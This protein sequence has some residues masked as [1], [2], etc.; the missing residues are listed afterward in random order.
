MSDASGTGAADTM[1]SGPAS[2][3]TGL[4]L[5]A[6]A[7]RT[8]SPGRT[9]VSKVVASRCPASGEAAFPFKGCGPHID[10]LPLVSAKRTTQ[11][12]LFTRMVVSELVETDAI[13]PEHRI[14]ATGSDVVI[15]ATFE[16]QEDLLG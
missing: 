5:S 3:P 13:K 12:S 11:E 9:A 1:L 6:S 15:E 10:K 16:R 8:A 2:L 7:D 4:F 14:V